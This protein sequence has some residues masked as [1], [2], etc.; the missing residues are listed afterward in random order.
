MT[1]IFFLYG[2]AGPGNIFL[3]LHKRSADG[4]QAGDK[5]PFLPQFPENFFPHAGHDVHVANHVRAVC[6]FY[7]DLG[8]R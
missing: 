6:Y 4:M 8:N 2:R 3:S 7:A 5:L 1:D